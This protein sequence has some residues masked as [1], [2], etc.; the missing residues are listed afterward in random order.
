M[1]IE[2]EREYLTFLVEDDMRSKLVF[3]LKPSFTI[4]LLKKVEGRV[5]KNAKESAPVIRPA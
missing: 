4:F 5:T 3:Q 1:A 2:L